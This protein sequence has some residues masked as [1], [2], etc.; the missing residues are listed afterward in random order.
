M[1][2]DPI[3]GHLRSKMEPIRDVAFGLAASDEKNRR[4]YGAVFASYLEPTEATK[5]LL[6]KLAHDEHAPVSGTAMDT[7]FGMG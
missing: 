5:E 3:L 1:M 2:P 6:E 7:L 4:F